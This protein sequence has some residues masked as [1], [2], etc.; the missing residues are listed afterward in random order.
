MAMAALQTR[1]LPDQHCSS[2]ITGMRQ[3]LLV[4]YR[5]SRI[6]CVRPWLHC[7]FAGYLTQY[8]P[9]LALWIMK[10]MGP[11]RAAQL[12]GG[13][14]GYDLKAMLFGGAAKAVKAE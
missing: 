14:S 9:A 6:S 4:V 13:G 12:K 1:R 2:H 5:H 3:S 8:S 10:R 7:K 11:L